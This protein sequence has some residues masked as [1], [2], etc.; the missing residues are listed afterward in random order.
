[1][2][3]SLVPL[4]TAQGQVPARIVVAGERASMRFPPTGKSLCVAEMFFF[5]VADGKVLE[6]FPTWDRIPRAAT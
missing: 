6:S 1:M 4:T 2:N 3:S 5:R